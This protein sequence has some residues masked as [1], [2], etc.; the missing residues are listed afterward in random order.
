[1]CPT[2]GLC[3]N[4]LTGSSRINAVLMSE[5]KINGVGTGGWPRKKSTNDVKE[6]TN[7]TDYSELERIAHCWKD[8]ARLPSAQGLNLLC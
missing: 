2:N 5:G 6:W 3:L 8:L 4:V 7:V 1:M